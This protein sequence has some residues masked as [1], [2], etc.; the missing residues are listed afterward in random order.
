M[1]DAIPF[2]VIREEWMRKPGFKE[3]YE[4]YIEESSLV[5]ALYQAQVQS[6]I[7]EVELAEKMGIPLSAL[8]RLMGGRSNPSFNTLRRLAAATGTK[9]RIQFE[10]I[11]KEGG[12]KKPKNEK[13]RK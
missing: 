5:D 8:R 11:A 6:G 3:G 9:V 4:A 7:T 12:P 10:P 13:T 2:S 1:K